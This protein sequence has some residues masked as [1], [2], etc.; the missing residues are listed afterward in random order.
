ME[1]NSGLAREKLNLEQFTK[2]SIDVD[3]DFRKVRYDNELFSVYEARAFH[4]GRNRNG[5]DVTPEAVQKAAKYF[6]NLPLYCMLNRSKDDFVEHYR[7]GKDFIHTDNDVHVFGI[8][9]ETT[10]ITFSEENGKNYVILDVIIFKNLLPSITSILE[11]R[12][13]NIKL[14]IEFFLIDQEVDADN[15][16]VVNE[17][18]P[19]AIVALGD[20]IEE[21]M[22]G[23]RLDLV[24]FVGDKTEQKMIDNSNKFYCS[25]AS[26]SKIALPPSVI[27]NMKKGLELRESLGRGGN[28]AAEEL[29]I[30][31]IKF[32]FIFEDDLQKIKEYFASSPLQ[33]E[34][35]KITSNKYVLQLLYGGAEILSVTNGQKADGKI[36]EEGGKKME[37]GAKPVETPENVQNA[38]VWVDK[39]VTVTVEQHTFEPETGK[40]T[41]E[42]AS[43]TRH[44]GEIVHTEDENNE[45]M[46]AAPQPVENG[47]QAQPETNQASAPPA[48]CSEEKPAEAKPDAGGEMPKK[49][50]SLDELKGEVERLKG[51]N[52]DLKRQNTELAASFKKEKDELLAKNAILEADFKKADEGLKG[53]QRKEEIAHSRELVLKVNSILNEKEK[54]ELLA[55][56]ETKT[57][58]EIKALIYEKAFY[59]VSSG[60]A[61]EASK[62]I[63]GQAANPYFNP[64][65]ERKEDLTAKFGRTGSSCFVGDAVQK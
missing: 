20:G 2:K 42:V 53:Y 18:I 5:Y 8:I 28:K 4:T 14:S 57:M 64:N 34:G 23:S 24:R 22:Q 49:E 21:G 41:D 56:C 16:I 58:S 15:Y 35:E 44:E 7:K 63:P 60:S 31:A 48:A 3:F 50:F 30:E 55:A 39:S 17:M 36:T 1:L 62:I 29:A 6:C 52:V 11:D 47:A 9:P 43:T 33:P 27:N 13:F 26:R 19:N 38:E 12:K 32:G 61:K 54:D 46:S 40:S 59:S 51:E 10:Q 45:Q 37:E 25:F 65:A